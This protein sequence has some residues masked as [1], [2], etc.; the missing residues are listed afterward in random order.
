[1][2][3]FLFHL[4]NRAFI[5]RY[6]LHI[7]EVERIADILG[8]GSADNEQVNPWDVIVVAA[9]GDVTTFSPEFMEV[10][11]L[12]HDNFRFGNILEDDFERLITKALVA[13]THAQI[14]RGVERCRADCAYFSV[15]GGGAPT[16]K[17]QET[18]S[19]DVAET[20]FC[21]LSVQTA[22]EALRKFLEWATAPG[23][24]NRARCD[25]PFA[26]SVKS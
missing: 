9:N 14:Q 15:C 6:P 24:K 11:S 19:L 16:N 4:L 1:V 2:I 18:G 3:D 23:V 7:K 12:F 21:R 25:A 17:F 5:E 13:T 26:R 8:H 10:R 20:L 22:A